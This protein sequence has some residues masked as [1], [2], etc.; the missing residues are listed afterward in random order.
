VTALVA[1]AASP[2]R[3]HNNFDLLR[4]LAAWFV[5]FSH[6][7]PL[8]GQAIADPFAR[9]VGIDTLGGIGVAIFF[10]LS[11]YL[12]TISRE[13]SVSTASF[14]GK[15]ASRIF[16]ALAVVICLSVLVLGPSLTT[17]PFSEYVR[18]PQTRAYFWN[19]AAWNIHYGLPGV[20]ATNPAPNAVNGSLWSLPYEIRCYLVLAALWFLPMSRKLTTS[21]MVLTFAIMLTLRPSP[22]A[23]G[24]FEKYMGLDYYTVKLGLYFCVGA[25]F[26]VWR[27]AIRPPLFTGSCV[28]AIALLLP[29]SSAQTT[30][31]VI[32]FSMFI[33]AVGLHPRLLPKLPEKMGDWSYGL[34]LYG[35]PVQQVL[36]LAGLGAL[37]VAGFTVAS[38]IVAT[39][40]A[41]GSWFLIER[42]ALSIFR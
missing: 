18:H 32:G 42:P 31:F 27:S 22:P 29:P 17:L 10:V 36:A 28:A 13:R 1:T 11:G 38:T 16:P 33:L 4:L 39:I 34:Y 41:A 5:L 7:Y 8:S 9:T 21:L 37:G 23:V 2:D 40:C 19:I 35:F 14:A 15:R 12:V 30:L 6:S 26:A 25:W 20:F 3:R 24:V